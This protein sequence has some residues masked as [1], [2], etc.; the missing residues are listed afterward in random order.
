MQM[1]P[2][3][4]DLERY[5]NLPEPGAARTLLEYAIHADGWLYRAFISRAWDVFVNRARP[6]FPAVSTFY[7]WVVANKM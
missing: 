4:V 3:G 7:G 1:S 6:L 5:T 2:N